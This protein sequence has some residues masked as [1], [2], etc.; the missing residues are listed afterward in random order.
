MS[1]KMFHRLVRSVRF[2]DTIKWQSTRDRFDAF[3]ANCKT[4]DSLGFRLEFHEMS[5]AYRGK[6]N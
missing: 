4:A 5:E 6:Y 2:D 1:K 3:V